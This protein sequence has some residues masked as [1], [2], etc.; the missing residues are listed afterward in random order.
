MLKSI[1]FN[2]TFFI[3]GNM[4]TPLPNIWKLLLI[5]IGNSFLLWS[6]QVLPIL[7][8]N[9]FFRFFDNKWQNHC[10]LSTY[11]Q[12]FFSIYFAMFVCHCKILQH[13]LGV[14]NWIKK[15]HLLVVAIYNR[16]WFFSYSLGIVNWRKIN[17]Y[18]VLPY[19]IGNNFLVIH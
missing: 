7:L 19:I 5:R 17:T 15:Q 13:L 18:H 4:K 3:F 6:Y 1:I 9:G 10:L 16:Q 8:G 2:T 11:R 14:V 12:Q